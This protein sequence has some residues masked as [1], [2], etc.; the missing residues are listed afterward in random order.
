M[1]AVGTMA[2]S[3][4]QTSLIFPSL[5]SGF[6]ERLFTLPYGVGKKRNA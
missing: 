5:L 1:L 2:G 6:D 3:D 4:A